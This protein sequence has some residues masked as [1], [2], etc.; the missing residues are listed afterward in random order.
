MLCWL[1]PSPQKTREQQEAMDGSGFLEW[2]GQAAHVGR[3]HLNS[4]AS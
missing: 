3:E 4:T 1:L 2:Q